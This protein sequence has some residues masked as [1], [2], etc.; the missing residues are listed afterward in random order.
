MLG[1]PFTNF[2]QIN[3]KDRNIK[4][5]EN[6]F[7]DVMIVVA[8]EEQM[9]IICFINITQAALGIRHNAIF[10]QPIPGWQSTKD[11]SLKVKTVFWNV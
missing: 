10:L 2:I 5:F 11:A 6:I 1:N 9:G 4:P 8:T 7:K 3:M